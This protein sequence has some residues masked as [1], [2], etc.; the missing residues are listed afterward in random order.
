MVEHQ[1]LA[2]INNMLM[3]FTKAYCPSKIRFARTSKI[4]TIFEGI[5]T[6][7]TWSDIRKKKGGSFILWISYKNKKPEEHYKVVQE[8]MTDYANKVLLLNSA[9]YNIKLIKNMVVNPTK[10]LEL[11]LQDGNFILGYIFP[12]KIRE[13]SSVEKCEA[14]ILQTHNIYELVK[15]QQSVKNCLNYIY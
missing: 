7:I 6:H 3:A 1:K 13:L 9:G 2:L 10:D 15:L 12:T 8:M 11:I 4:D 14:W 5:L